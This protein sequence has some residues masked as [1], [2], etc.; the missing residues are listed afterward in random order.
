MVGSKAYP[1]VFEYNRGDKFSVNIAYDIL[2]NTCTFHNFIFPTNTP[3]DVK[4]SFLEEAENA[5][6]KT[7]IDMGDDD[8]NNIIDVTGAY[9]GD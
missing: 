3:I 4:Q 2:S 1:I 9:Y 5:A 8:K 6:N 7:I